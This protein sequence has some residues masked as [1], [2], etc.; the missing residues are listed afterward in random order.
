MDLKE[1][2]LFSNEGRHPWE[3]ARLEIIDRGLRRLAREKGTDD[4]RVLDIGS[5]DMFVVGELARRHPSWQFQAVDSYFSD[6][7]IAQFSQQH[8]GLP[9]RMFRSLDECRAADPAPADAV[10]FFDVLEHMEDEVAFLKVLKASGAVAAHTRLFATI[11]SYQALFCSHDVF[12]VH[13]RRYTVPTMTAAMNKAGFERVRGG[14]FFFS[15]LPPRVLTVLKEKILGPP[16]GDGTGLS[17]WKGG[18]FVSSLIKGVLL[19]DY[20]FS[21]LILKT[22]LRIPGLSTFVVCKPSAS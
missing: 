9:I 20:Y 3:L 17:Q 6:A 16:K 4:L 15:L 7:H 1:A 10:T 14:Y 22:G 21:A 5:G 12:L 8:A 2:T 11:P 13:Y 19:A 18:K